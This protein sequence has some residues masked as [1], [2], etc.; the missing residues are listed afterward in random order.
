MAGHSHWAGIKHKKALVDSKRGKLWSRL[1][2][3]IIV[4][5]KFGGGDPERNF[6]LR[7]AIDDARSISMPKENIERA[8]KRGIGEL[9]G[10]DVEELIYEGYAFGGV[11]VICDIVTDNR[12]RTASEVRA[13][14]SK[15]G[16]N[17]GSAGCV[18]YLFERKGLVVFSESTNETAVM[19]MALSVGADNLEISQQ[20][21]LMC[22][23]RPDIFG[24]F[25]TRIK[26][27]E[28][29]I[30]FAEVARIPTSRIGL[31][32]SVL[33][34]VIPLIETLEEHEDVEAVTSN[35]NYNKLDFLV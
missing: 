18:S 15:F 3:S 20:G 23:C 1:S 21:R 26:D 27:S 35:V 29:E 14:F 16:G 5:A 25:L 8:I 34:K 31:D 2:K 13:I 33:G 32:E 7:K 6:R 10:G 24:E 22:Y 12:N 28:L 9:D 30:E 4:A 19:E 11:A 17:L